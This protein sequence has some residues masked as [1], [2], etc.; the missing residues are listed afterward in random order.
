M[1]WQIVKSEQ[2]GNKLGRCRRRESPSKRSK[3]IV[4]DGEI[5][6]GTVMPL[7]ICMD[8]RALDYGDIVPFFNKL[9]EIFAHP[10]IIQTWK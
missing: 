10:E 3:P 8:H 4:V 2:K 6:I 7:S 1:E 9:D 5:K